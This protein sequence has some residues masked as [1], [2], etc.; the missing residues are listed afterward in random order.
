M[1][2]PLRS[3]QFLMP[4]PATR[5]NGALE[6]AP[7]MIRTGASCRIARSAW[8]VAT[9]AML[10]SRAVAGR[11]GAR[12]DRVHGEM[13]GLV[14]FFCS[15]MKCGRLS[16]VTLAMLER[17]QCHCGACGARYRVGD[18][19][20]DKPDQDLATHCEPLGR[21]SF[22]G[23]SYSL[24]ARVRPLARC[25]AVAGAGEESGRPDTP[26]A[27]AK[28]REGAVTPPLC[29]VPSGLCDVYKIADKLLFYHVNSGLL[30]NCALQ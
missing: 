11:G 17:G 1:V 21:A 16:A 27:A 23:R 7:A 13:F 28:S 24:T 14:V 5:R 18:D 2:L 4:L 19:G 30:T 26:M 15:A 6:A 9:C 12:H 10:R 29:E 22:G 25:P 8:S 20:Q 3:L